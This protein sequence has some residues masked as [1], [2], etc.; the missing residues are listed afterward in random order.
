MSLFF[1]LDDDDDDPGE[2]NGIFLYI[3][4]EHKRGLSVTVLSYNNKFSA[5]WKVRVS[6]RGFL[7]KML[8]VLARCDV[9][10]D[11]DDGGFGWILFFFFTT[12][13]FSVIKS[14]CCQNL[15]LRSLFFVF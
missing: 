8:P 9:V 1:F 3:F 14:H 4:Q 7:A 12:V 15:A 2:F 5:A 6:E 13:G 11:D 10:G